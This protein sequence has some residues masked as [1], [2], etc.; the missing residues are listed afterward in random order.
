VITAAL[1]ATGQA[2]FA[3]Q[4]PNAGTQLQQ[5]P[6]APIPEKAEPV[7]RIKRST[8]LS[9]PAA[10]GATVRVSS[11]RVTGNSVFT[12]AELIDAANIV[13]RSELTLS[14]LR[15]AASRI[16]AYYNSRG[17]FL[18]QAYLPAQDINDGAVTIAVVE[19]RYGKIDV[20][21]RANLSPRLAEQVLGGLGS[22][23]PVSN[24]QLE[25]RLLLLSDIPGVRVTSTLAPGAQ[26][27]TSDLI[28]VI[29][30]GREMT[31]SVE[32]DNS[33]NRYT[34]ALRA[35]G[36]INLNNPAGIGDLLSLRLLASEGG[37]AYGRASYQA[38]VGGVILG[39]AYTHLTYELGREFESLDA[40][41]SADI[42][43]VF[44]SYPLVRSRNANLYALAGFDVKQLE[45]R[46]G[47]VSAESDKQV[48]VATLGFSG[49]SR[50]DFGAG[51]WN[52]YSAGL[53]IGN[54][55]IESP[56]ERAADALTARSDGGFSKV[57]ASFARLQTVSG[58]LSLYTLVRGQLAFENLDSSEKMQ[59]GGAYGVR[60][61][62]EGEA[63][64]DQGYIA[65]LE[66]RLMLS[67][68]TAALPGQ[69]QLIGFVDAG[70][71][72]FSHDPWFAGSN[73]ASRSGFGAGL[74][75]F[76]PHD[77]VL[78]ASY[79]RKLGDAEVTSGPDRAGRAW[80]QLSKLF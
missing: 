61:Y 53:A 4:A 21:N 76:A 38:P 34:G 63:Y 65:T 64:G 54:L 11:L 45:D 33:G 62:P 44:G 17:Y 26:V 40:D 57:Q 68:W 67:R 72:E 41:G 49:D 28:V 29:A 43:G 36:S 1:L 37:L 73:H 22:G 35:G 74:S 79:A 48:K 25:R 5:I 13:P 16:S 20:R 56:V 23:A 3:Q 15:D 19:G 69:L 24:A 9:E 60:A 30:P 8:S 51:G 18:A 71:V 10:G 32:A 66:V 59:L 14:E 55:D 2:A 58:P 70:E 75:W 39:V 52:F 80:F 46:I 31:G 27:G 47:L 7:I 42:F 12:E 78:K 6:P 50:D 77:L